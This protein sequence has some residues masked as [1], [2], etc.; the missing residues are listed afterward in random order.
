MKRYLSL[1]TYH[2]SLAAAVLLLL[3]ACA[4]YDE[5]VTLRIVETTDVHGMFFPV[6]PD[7]SARTGTMARVCSYVDSLRGV[8]GDNVLLL[9]NG[10]ILQGKPVNYFANF[11][12]TTTEQIAASVVNYMRYDAEGVGNH[13][14]E[15]GHAV[16]DKWFS[17]VKCPMLGA[18]IVNAATGQG[19]C[20]ASEMKLASIS[21]PQ[22]NQEAKPQP[23]VKPYVVF[24]R[25]SVKIAV[26]GLL[27]PAIPNW[28]RPA[29]W[30]GLQFKEMVSNAQHWMDEIQQKEHPDVVIGLFHSGRTGGITTDQ[31]AENASQ[32]VA[33]E[34]DGF[35]LILFGHD[36]IAYSGTVESPSGR[37]VLLLNPSNDA[38]AVGDAK[39]VI[40][41]KNGKIVG[42]EI[43]GEIKNICAEPID[44]AYM[45][46]FE[47]YMKRLAD[48]ANTRVATLTAPIYMSD[49]F[50]GNSEL[51]DL[52][53]SMQRQLAKADI[54]FCAPLTED[55]VI[56][57]GD[58]RVS[59]MF[60]L[61]RYE[62]TLYRMRLT[63]KE[64]RNFLE[65]SY[66]LWTNTMKSA[67]DHALNLNPD[68][69]KKE[70]AWRFNKSFY[71]FDSASGID[72]EVD[73]S[74]PEGQKVRILRLSDGRDFDENAEYTVAINSYRGNGGGE[75]LTRGAGI[76]KDSL[77]ARIEW[78]SER[79]LR[80][81][82][83]EELKKMG[84]ITPQAASNWK[85]VPEGWAR[86]ALERDRQF[87]FH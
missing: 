75:H 40:G 47:P 27:T 63:G 17:E 54:S 86:P 45:A 55:G 74:A 43:T 19:L 33:A 21:E 70:G 76:D 46:H 39:I 62:N 14:I 22:P 20:K 5:T 81:Y 35:D 48:Y 29:L 18:N 38:Q 72:Y 64:I 61:Y 12:D 52:I 57:A 26:L 50:F 44:T 10:D 41:K 67:D 82:L 69:G 32:Q 49:A 59:D 42:K 65:W 13:D 24:E 2:L 31:Y 53:H 30:S 36:H 23:Y 68:Y 71:Q 77:K 66:S 85:F 60:K 15:P 8:Y 7:G 56:E 51:I 73:L 58:I 4:N 28:L 1:V 78:E 11:V 9:D 87:L 16:Y 3:S 84:T 80:Y 37:K 25:D 79:D 83:M 6:A 34:V